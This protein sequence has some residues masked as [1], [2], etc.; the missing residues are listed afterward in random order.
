MSD[1]LPGAIVGGYRLLDELG[2]GGMGVV[3]RA[4]EP[5]TGRT[6]AL[7]VV[8]EGIAED[9]V[10]R[11]RFAREAEAAAALDH[12]H[13]L[14]VLCSGE[15]RGQPYL[16][17]PLVDGTDLAGV[18]R[19]SGPFT[20]DRATRV[21]DQIASALDAAHR[22]GLV[23]RD[24][25]PSN[26]L[27]DGDH[28]L[29]ADFGLTTRT[30]S[31]TGLTGTGSWVGTLDY[32]SPE[33]VKGDPV[34]GR[35]DVYALG[36]LL[37]EL[38]A[39]R[40]PHRRDSDVATI[41]AH[42]ADPVPSLTALV[43]ELPITVDEAVSAALAKNPHDRP[44]TA[45]EFASMLR[46]AADQARKRAPAVPTTR[47]WGGIASGVGCAFLLAWGSA[48]MVP[49]H[50]LPDGSSGASELLVYYTADRAAPLSDAAITL[51][52]VALLAGWLWALPDLL[53]RP[54]RGVTVG[55]RYT[56]AAAA[57]VLAVGEILRVA[58]T[59]RIAESGN[60]ALVDALWASAWTV[61][62]AGAVLVVVCAALGSVASCRVGGLWSVRTAACVV[63]VPGGSVLVVA[64]WER[65]FFLWAVGCGAV[66]LWV[67]V[68]SL[69]AVV[70]LTSPGR[71]LALGGAVMGFHPLLGMLM[72]LP[73]APVYDPADSSP[74]QIAD[75]YISAG[76]AVLP[77]AVVNAASAIALLGLWWVLGRLCAAAG[78]WSRIG[79]V[80]GIAGST[81]VLVSVLLVIAAGLTPPGETT[82]IVTLDSLSTFADQAG[83]VLLA[84]AVGAFS[85]AWSRTTTSARWLGYSG[86]VVA[87]LSLGLGALALALGELTPWAPA[88]IG[89]NS[90]WCVSASVMAQRWPR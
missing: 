26:V 69:R 57:A 49:P 46:G 76:P 12:P 67:A 56:G 63:A 84:I 75:Y 89:A 9:P 42:V 34:D 7:K 25:K 4:V 52:A 33:Q 70:V 53:G 86:L 17:M 85:I 72:P 16:V 73:S 68:V 44:A 27:L 19:T 35:A 2:R 74:E 39:G 59:F 77:P 79:R 3:F 5:V 24:V 15:D 28:V 22:V 61:S 80:G 90:L 48:F 54:G 13:V 14:P 55:I 50:V 81:L 65:E 83:T 62:A 82:R 88:V 45:G 37:F 60:G 36:C 87:G 71:R 20:L 32:V 30:S 66:G 38:L 47:S 43:P 41:W 21:V 40:P 58:P 78:T 29:L 11:R 64:G 10:V 1:V 31:Q 51:T 18:L 23:H 8:A 6:V